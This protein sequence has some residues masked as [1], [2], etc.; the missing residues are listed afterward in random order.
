MLKYNDAQKI[1]YII[2]Y[3]DGGCSVCVRELVEHCNRIFPGFIWE[4]TEET[5]YL[6]TD[7][8]FKVPHEIVKVQKKT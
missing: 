4:Y 6:A 1:A 3:A 5:E 2:G 7:Y 8:G